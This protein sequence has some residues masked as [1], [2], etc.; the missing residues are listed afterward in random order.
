MYKVLVVE[1]MDITRED[2]MALIDWKQ[3]DFELLPG[4]R[5][6]KIGLEYARK[7]H[8]DIVITDIKMPI[9]T[10]LTMIEEIMEQ[11][12]H[13]KYILLTAYE[14][15]EY[16]KKALT[17][18]IHSFILKY[19]INREILLAELRKCQEEL[20]MQEEIEN[21]TIRHKLE[22]L[23]KGD[24]KTIYVEEKFFNW[25]GR[26][27][28]LDIWRWKTWTEFGEEN[29]RD[30]LKEELRE[31]RFEF[32]KIEA[33]E[34]IVFLRIPETHSEAERH[35]YLRGFIIAFQYT[36]EKILESCTAIAIGGYVNC[37]RD[38]GECRQQ[39]LEYLS[40]R[41]FFRGNCILDRDSV[42]Q[43]PVAPEIMEEKYNNIQKSIR[44]N[45]FLTAK[46]NIRE[47][48]ENE[49]ANA[50]NVDLLKKTVVKL[51]YFLREKG[52][53]INLEEFDTYLESISMNILTDTIYHTEERFEYLLDILHEY[54]EQ[55]YSRKVRETINY[56]R[57]HYMENVGLNEAADFLDITPIYLSHLFKKETGLTFSA[58]ITKLRME[59]AIE[60]LRRGDLK[61][62]EI[63]EIVG[64][65]TV[66]YFSKVFKKETGK[67]PKE[68][69]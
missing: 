23:L 3:Y 16:A 43:N 57:K 30:V 21:V 18:G 63:S 35:Q 52:Y 68:F 51:S 40:R 20:T 56:L 4:A 34:Y 39:A 60:L 61:I 66:Q 2:I 53:A 58:Y 1:D 29:L 65:Q 24:I 10:G 59:K 67:S 32:L 37:N 17:L 62:Y 27:V 64:Y 13:I 49:I 9:M 22:K 44:D 54:I 55:K 33:Q 31:Y 46:K 5:N 15:F 26:S 36:C 12:K 48:F 7:F 41:I 14:E 69:V 8:P 28:L 11:D 19:E 25:I 47:L 6:G 50:R 38:I 42:M 45:Q